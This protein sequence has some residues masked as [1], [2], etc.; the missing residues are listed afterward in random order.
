VIALGLA[1]GILNL[2]GSALYAYEVVK[3]RSVPERATWFILTVLG[4]VAFFSQ[5][6]MGAQ[7]SLWFVGL[8]TVGVCVIFCLSIK[9]GVGGLVKRDALILLAAA[10]GIILWILTDE[11]LLAL[12][13]VI[14]VRSIALGVT[15]Y[16]T[17][18]N[19][20]SEATLPWLI[21]ALSAVLAIASVGTMQFNL[22]LY[23]MYVILADSAVMIA[24]YHKHLQVSRVSQEI[25]SYIHPEAQ[26]HKQP[27]D[28]DIV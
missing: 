24:K 27:E 21:Y 7:A 18:K 28:R 14:L 23:P 22:L 4:L 5:K 10:F 6:G 16:K 9:Y 1:S 11:P 26:I 12:V 13:V 19:P 17:Y 8:Q 20:S 3:K 2:A 25:S 15:V